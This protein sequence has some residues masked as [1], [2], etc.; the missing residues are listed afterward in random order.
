MYGH[1]KMPA[2]LPEGQPSV[3]EIVIDVVRLQRAATVATTSR[4]VVECLHG[5][6]TDAR[7]QTKRSLVALK[8]NAHVECDK[9]HDAARDRTRLKL[10]S[11]PEL[12]ERKRF[13]CTILDFQTHF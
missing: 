1:E 6:L 4:R 8:T 13:E 9:L 11:N 3:Q 7:E 2:L 12:Q 10:L 5:A